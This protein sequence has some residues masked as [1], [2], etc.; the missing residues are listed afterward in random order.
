[1]EKKENNNRLQKNQNIKLVNDGSKVIAVEKEKKVE[2]V[3]VTRKKRN[4]IMYESKLGT[5]KETD[6]TKIA[7]KKKREIQ[8]RVEDRIVQ[9]R[10]KKGIFG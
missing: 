8:P 2:E 6:Y 9:K 3:G 7:A 1:M 10:K 4:F 5:E